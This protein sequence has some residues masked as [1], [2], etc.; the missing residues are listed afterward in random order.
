MDTTKHKHLINTFVEVQKVV[1]RLAWVFV[2]LYF[3]LSFLIFFGGRYVRP[4]AAGLFM[5]H[6]PIISLCFVLPSFLILLA[7]VALRVAYEVPFFQKENVALLLR[8]PAF[9]VVTY[10]L[11]LIASG[12]PI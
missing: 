8:L 10:W 11:W 6:G 5:N 9:L 4:W 12:V 7:R 1:E 2:G 3:S